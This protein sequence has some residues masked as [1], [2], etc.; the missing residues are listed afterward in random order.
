MKHMETIWKQIESWLE[1]NAPEMLNTLLPGATDKEILAAEKAMGIEFPEEVKESYRLH[2]GQDGRATPLMGEWQLLSL[3][4]MVSQW[5]V[6]K[7]LVDKGKFDDA[8]VKTVGPVRADWY[9]LKWIP[10]AYNGAGDFQC[11]D[12]DP[13]PKGKAGQIISFWH[14]KDERKEL[15]NSYKAWLKGFANDLKKGKYKVKE[16]GLV[17]SG[18]RRH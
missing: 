14:M 3:K 18:S 10:L 6:M 5:K 13:P 4:N 17:L 15:A 1:K 8:E 11:L 12:L 7:K 9:N 2:N 16:E